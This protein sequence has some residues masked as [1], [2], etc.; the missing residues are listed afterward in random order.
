MK[1]TLVELPATLNG[2]LW[3]TPVIDFFS[4]YKLPSRAIPTIHAILNEQGYKDV[5][6]INPSYN[7]TGMLTKQDMERLIDS[8]VVGISTITRTTLQS[9]QLADLL[10]EYNPNIKIIMGGTHVS[11]LAEEALEHCDYVVRQEGDFTIIEL[12]QRLK[13]NLYAPV[14]NDIK[15]ISFKDKGEIIHNPARPFL[16]NEE[17]S[18]L[19]FPLYNP[20]E[21]EKCNTMVV[22]TSRGCPFKCSYCSV[23]QNFGSQFRYMDDDY[24]IES[25][26]QAVKANKRRIF[27]ADDSFAANPTRTKRILYKMLEQNIKMPRWTAQVRIESAFDDELLHLLKTTH[28]TYVAVGLESVNDETLKLYN[29]KATKEKNALGIQKYHA[30]GLSVH[31]MFVLGAET[32]DKQTFYDTLEFAKKTK[33][34]TVQFFSFIPLPGTPMTKHYEEQKKILTKAY[35]KYDAQHVVIAHPK[36]EPSEMQEVLDDLSLKF[37]S[38]KEAIRTLFAGHNKDYGFFIRLIGKI[39]MLKMLRYHKEYKLGLIEIEK[40]KKKLTVDFEKWKQ[41]GNHYIRNGLEKQYQ[42]K[43]ERLSH[44][45]SKLKESI[46]KKHYFSHF[47]YRFIRDYCQSILKRFD[48]EAQNYISQLKN[49]EVEKRTS[50]QVNNEIQSY[51]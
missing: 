48:D 41:E 25:F 9:Y 33:I 14:L 4:V 27:V 49:S 29:K 45:Y 30:A 28:C 5:M 31:G 8:D 23:I 43:R 36:M 2:T 39:L 16:S 24:V 13:D 12:M 38:V 32:D 11:A 35:H 51:S 46:L 3:E 37:Y 40:W 7:K 1:I 50:S 47:Q 42:E 20:V 44:H 18:N 22:I 21:I 10:K 6:Q 26:K 17:L 34:D 15:G 19:P